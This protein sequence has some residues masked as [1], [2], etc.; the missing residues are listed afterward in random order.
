MEAGEIRNILGRHAVLQNNVFSRDQ[1]PTYLPIGGYVVNTD[2]W[3]GPGIHWIALWVLEDTIEFMDSFGLEP[4]YYG[5]SFALPVLMNTRQL[6]S[7]TASTCGAYCLYFL[8]FRALGL[9][10]ATILEFFSTD[11]Q[12]NDLH[13]TRFV[14]LL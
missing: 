8:Y 1:L 14:E 12:L 7:D 5:W 13:V 9:N 6:Q 11:T 4:A 3:D 2:N 10:M